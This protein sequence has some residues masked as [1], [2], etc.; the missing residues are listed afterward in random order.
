MRTDTKSDSEELLDER[1]ESPTDSND[2]ILDQ[3]LKLTLTP[4][5]TK[6]PSRVLE[7]TDSNIETLLGSKVA[8]EAFTDIPANRQLVL[9]L[10]DGTETN[11]QA[12][13]V[14][15]F[16]FAVNQ[17][18]KWRFEVEANQKMTFKSRLFAKSQR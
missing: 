4:T 16:Q 18:G 1:N 12:S 14:V 11:L 17:S 13:G 8:G 9:I 5:Y 7:N 15:K 10:P 2:A 6:L 3:G